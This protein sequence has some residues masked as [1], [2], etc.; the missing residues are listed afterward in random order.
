MFLGVDEFLW[1]NLCVVRLLQLPPNTQPHTRNIET[2]RRPSNIDN[3]EV[4][5][6]HTTTGTLNVQPPPPQF[7]IT[8]IFLSNNLNS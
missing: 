4:H 1:C 5:L 8:I 6:H 2:F 3:Y 7:K